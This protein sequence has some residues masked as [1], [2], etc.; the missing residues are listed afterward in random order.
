MKHAVHIVLLGSIISL[1]VAHAAQDRRPYD[2][3]IEGQ[4]RE[5]I[6]RTGETAYR[7]SG[8]APDFATLDTNHD[9]SISATEASGYALLAN[10][11]QMADSNRDGRISKR[12]YERW[13]QRP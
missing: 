1:G 11:F 7:P 12:E 4:A 6:I 10:D 8:P 13:A 9:G 3:R 2:T 5:L